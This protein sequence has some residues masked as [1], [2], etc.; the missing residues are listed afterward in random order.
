MF[1]S[2]VLLALS[3]VCVSLNLL[4]C[5]IQPRPWLDFGFGSSCISSV[6]LPDTGSSQFMP[7]LGS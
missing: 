6:V 5:T 4:A 1:S 7:G 3:M 2:V